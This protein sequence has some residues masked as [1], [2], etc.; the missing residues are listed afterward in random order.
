[1][2]KVVAVTINSES[3]AYPYTVTEDRRVINDEVG[4]EPIVVFHDSGAVSALD[5]RRIARSREVGST[6]VFRR[7]VN[8]QV[9]SFRYRDGKFH[10]G[11][12]LS[13]W[14]VTGQAIE[15]PLKG[16]RL[17]PLTHGDYFAFAWLVFK[18][19]TKVYQ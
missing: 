6:G 17:E 11:E 16:N 3:K 4:G 7:E 18:P 10:D 19:E 13:V 14:D 2:E 1:M 9:L 12:T 5:R 8:G 15:G